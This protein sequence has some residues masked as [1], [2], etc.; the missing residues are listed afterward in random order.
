MSIM[1]GYWGKILCVDLTTAKVSESTFDDA[2]AR[3]YLGGVGFASRLVY[4]HVSRNTN[5]LGP[6]NVLVFATGPYQAA[7]IAGA[8]RCALGA[9]SPL[10]G[11]WGECNGGGDIG[12]ELK[13]SG[14]DA[15]MITGRSSK[16]VYL[17]IKDG[18]VK[19]RDAS[20]FWGMDTAQVTDALKEAISD[21]R[22][23]VS[24]IG[25]GGENLIRYACIV[26]DKHGYF[27]RTGLG[28]VMGS[29]NLKA[30][31][32]RGTLKPPIANPGKLKEVYR[33]IVGRIKD[34][35]SVVIEREHG[36]AE[37]VVPREKNGLLPIQNWK[38]DTFPTVTKIG[39]PYMTEE[40]QIKPWSC[41]Y[42]FIGCH[43]KVTNPKYKG[44]KTSGLEYE[45]IA[46]IGSN[47]LIDNLD[48]LVRANEILNRYGVDTIE[49]GGILGWAFE[50][51]ERGLITKGD[52][53]GLEL[54]WG[55][56]EAMVQMVEKVCKRE[57]IGNLLAEGIR[58]CVD[59][60]PES[61]PFTV[62]SYGMSVAGH[63]PRAF[64]SMVIATIASTRGACH[65]HGCSE[66]TELGALV[67][68]LPGMDVLIDRFDPTNKGYISAI[69]QDLF[70]IWNSLTLCIIYFYSGVSLNDQVMLLNAITG[71][72]TTPQEIQKIGERI[73][74]L[75]HMFNLANGL[76]PEKEN[77]LPERLTL[78]HK[79]G[80]AAGQVL[81]WRDIL[82]EYW[83]T[84]NW[85]N[86]IPS[87]HKM[88]ELGLSDLKSSALTLGCRK[89]KE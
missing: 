3:K 14:Y 51:Y 37:E 26:N 10:T 86:G 32:V 53:D 24:A 89:Y 4:E 11:Y 52:T 5:P 83:Q 72:D 23:A 17:W 65:L 38:G 41:P 54:T 15:L 34:S 59:R 56:A 42:C 28:A 57:G 46:M 80:S 85:P 6:G 30:L 88:T 25:P 71:W 39:T 67:P 69:W 44:V 49:I 82:N 50:C 64:F 40:L 18:E 55:N 20:Q 9:K 35:P 13:R 60:I 36:Q 73:V 63:D 79:G 33:D 7:A 12:P 78:P 76:V 61:Q 2:F 75:Q 74:C 22:A 43:R 58:A 16:P 1:G 47:L 81:P 45:T 27:G 31:V 70:Q 8:G 87:T 21:K 68:E 84:K 19:I 29:K 62:E 48:A 77:V 66:G